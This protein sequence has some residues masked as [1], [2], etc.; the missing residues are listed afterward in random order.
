MAQDV[1]QPAVE[2]ATGL[3][4]SGK[5]YVVV[6]TLLIIFSGLAFYIIRIDK[7][8]GKLEKESK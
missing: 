7:R 8:L 1:A 4:S 2:M 3:R 6:I 5:I